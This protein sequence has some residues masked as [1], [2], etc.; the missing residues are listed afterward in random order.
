MDGP[1]LQL[2]QYLQHLLSYWWPFFRIMAVISLA[3]MF[4]HG[5][6]PLHVRIALAVAITVAIANALPTM[7]NV[8]PLSM[9]G[10]LTAVEQVA[11]GLMLG[12]ALQLVFTIFTLVGGVIATPM[13]LSMA[14][15]SDPVHGVSS[16]PI[17][18]QVYFILLVLLFFGIDG[19][20]IT[21][22]ILYHSFVYWPVGSGL[23]YDGFSTVL[24]AFSWVFSAAA[25]LAAPIVF[26]MF[27][28]Q[29]CFGLL[30]RISPSMNLFALGFPMAVVTGLFLIFLTLPNMADGYL[31]L[32][33]QL[34]TN[35]GVML[36]GNADG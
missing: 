2:S 19:H 3:P 11:V 1:L 35:L 13:G 33:H 18:Y 36:A 24:Y 27:V 8:D 14:M 28:V 25:L 17:L 32:T 12:L 5:A 22:S 15:V 6:V 4:S 34:L 16:S 30:N 7:P 20:L 21:V 31:N 10:V 26:C 23:Y 9:L 29:F